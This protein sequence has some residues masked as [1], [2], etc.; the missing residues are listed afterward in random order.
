M[1]PQKNNLIHAVSFN[2]IFDC[3]KFKIIIDKKKKIG[4]GERISRWINEYV[5]DAR[6]KIAQ[7]LE[8]YS[9]RDY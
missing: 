5:A 9:S 3:N 6:V 4:I 7:D 2:E 8:K 1:Q